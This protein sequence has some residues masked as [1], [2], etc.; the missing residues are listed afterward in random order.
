LTL[1]ASGLRKEAADAYSSE[2]AALVNFHEKDV[3]KK[4]EGRKKK[5]ESNDKNLKKAYWSMEYLP[6]Q[7]PWLMRVEKHAAREIARYPF[8]TLE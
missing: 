8:I 6:T 5:E 2:G 1:V 7:F 3:K 4:K